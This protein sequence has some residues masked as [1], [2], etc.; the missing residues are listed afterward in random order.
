[1]DNKKQDSGELRN[2]DGLQAMNAPKKNS[3]TNKIIVSTTSSPSSITNTRL[4]L[5][6]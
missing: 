2:A 3:E 6:K 5:P 4:E 1:M